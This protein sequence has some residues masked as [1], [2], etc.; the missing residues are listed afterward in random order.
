MG[1]APGTTP[2]HAGRSI[3][4]FKVFE[5]LQSSPTAAKTP[6]KEHAPDPRAAPAAPRAPG[7]ARSA[8]WRRTPPSSSS[9]QEVR[10]WWHSTPCAGEMGP[11]VWRHSPCGG[12]AAHACPCALSTHLRVHT[13]TPAQATA[14]EPC[15]LAFATTAGLLGAMESISEAQEAR[16]HRIVAVGGQGPGEAHAFAWYEGGWGVGMGREGGRLTRAPTHAR[17]RAQTQALASHARA[18]PSPKT[19]L[20]RWLLLSPAKAHPRSPPPPNTRQYRARPPP[21]PRTLVAP[22]SLPS[23]SLPAPPRPPPASSMHAPLPSFVRA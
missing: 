11:C 3:A 5:V 18:P 10:V 19:P 7:G 1:P 14:P 23:P 8:D 9:A 16:A 4:S 6:H 20:H 17:T 12:G 13:P 21:A 2:A 15:P 22:P